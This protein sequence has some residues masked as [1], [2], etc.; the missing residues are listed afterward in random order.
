MRANG[1]SERPAEPDPAELQREVVAARNDLDRLVGELDRRRHAFFDVRANFW[2]NPV[3]FVLGG[4]ALV[5]AAGATVAL[6][7]ARRR[8]YNAWPQR[9]RRLRRAVAEVV[10]QP[11]RLRQ[12]RK[13]G[14]VRKLGLAGGGAVASTLA[15]AATQRLLR[16]ARGG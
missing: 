2:R 7:V 4:L 11:D 13:P 5:T 16:T 6:V 1:R 12:P 9:M 10:R 15:K 3:R 14:T 8:R